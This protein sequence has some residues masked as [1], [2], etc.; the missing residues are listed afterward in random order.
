[1]VHP[2]H[3]RGAGGAHT[4]AQ[5]AILLMR[6]NLVNRREPDENIDDSGDCVA[7]EVGDAPVKQT[8][9]QPVEA[10]NNKEEERHGV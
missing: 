1:M 4:A 6:G 8:D 5:L 9:E 3:R 2:A 7:D 10:T